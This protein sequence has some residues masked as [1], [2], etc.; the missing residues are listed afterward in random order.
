MFPPASSIGRKRLAVRASATNPL[1]Q[2]ITSLEDVQ[3]RRSVYHPTYC[4]RNPG[5]SYLHHNRYPCLTLVVC[6]SIDFRI[7]HHVSL[8]CCY[9]IGHGFQQALV[10]GE[11]RSAC[12]MFE[13]RYG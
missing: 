10:R 12:H 1:L 3:E 9:E 11:S 4:F 2:L 7:G 6:H 5:K 13:Q 8:T